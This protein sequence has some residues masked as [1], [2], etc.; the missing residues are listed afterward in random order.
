MTLHLTWSSRLWTLLLLGVEV[1]LLR[2]DKMT[3][4]VSMQIHKAAIFDSLKIN[5]FFPI[6][7]MK[8]ILLSPNLVRKME[9]VNSLMRKI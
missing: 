7:L 4:I 2:S 9:T 8:M 5:I 6:S 1:F 3:L